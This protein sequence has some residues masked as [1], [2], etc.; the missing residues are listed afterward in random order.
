MKEC[1]G[2]GDRVNPLYNVGVGPQCFLTLKW[3]CR[4]NDF[5]LFRPQNENK[6]AAV[7]TWFA[8]SESLISN[9]DKSAENISKFVIKFSISWE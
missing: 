2:R 5:E 9:L 8:L 3:I 4:C 7:S 1:A 6:C